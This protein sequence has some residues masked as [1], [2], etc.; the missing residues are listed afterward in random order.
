MFVC[1]LQLQK[2][3][4]INTIPFNVY[5]KEV[6]GYF[7]KITRWA[8]NSEKIHSWLSI[9]EVADNGWE[10]R[11]AEIIQRN[12]GFLGF[13]FRPNNDDLSE[14]YGSSNNNNDTAK[15]AKWKMNPLNR[16]S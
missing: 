11:H 4:V 8:P 1:S 12:L 15:L 14:L 3:A 16:S 2:T 6:H 10:C 5:L 9:V 7:A 13:E